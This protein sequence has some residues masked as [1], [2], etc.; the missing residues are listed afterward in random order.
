MERRI[1]VIEYDGDMTNLGTYLDSD[2]QKYLNES[3]PNLDLSVQE[4]DPNTIDMSQFP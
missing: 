4:V 1:I 2:L 3:H